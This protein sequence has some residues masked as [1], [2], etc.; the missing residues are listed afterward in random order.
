MLEVGFS[1]FGPTLALHGT[2]GADKKDVFISDIYLNVY[3]TK[4]NS[5]RTLT[6]TAIRPNKL[7]VRPSSQITLEIP[8]AFIIKTE[9]PYKFH[10][11]FSDKNI[12]NDIQPYLTK[13]LSEWQ[14][15]LYERQNLI[16]KFM[17]DSPLSR[18][19]IIDKIYDND[20][21][22]QSKSFQEAWDILNRNN[23]WEPG[24]YE[25]E[26][27]VNAYKPSNKFTDNFK[28]EIS[29]EAFEKLRLNTVATLREICIG[30]ANYFFEYV[31]F[32]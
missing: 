14:T 30:K 4:D 32:K 23:Y 7:N 10:I 9:L 20:F 22:K 18:D 8:S 28:F 17:Q 11:F 2:L 13:F 1:S 15:F 26:L 21:S 12:Q 29:Q 3:R 31:D 5:T 27:V 16:S 6:W 24:T 25:V 19:S